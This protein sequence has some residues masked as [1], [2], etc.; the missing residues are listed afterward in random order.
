MF[1]EAARALDEANK[2]IVDEGQ[3][4]AVILPVRDGV[5]VV[6]WKD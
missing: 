5:T 4:E 1:D 2:A 6:R 3:V